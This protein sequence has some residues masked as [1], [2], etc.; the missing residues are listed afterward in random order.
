MG[1]EHSLVHG[2]CS[3]GLVTVGEIEMG[4]LHEGNPLLA[5]A[6]LL[7]ACRRFELRFLLGLSLERSAHLRVATLKSIH[8]GHELIR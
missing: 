1:R 4:V 3:Q 5:H 6:G 2:V 7:M 8:V